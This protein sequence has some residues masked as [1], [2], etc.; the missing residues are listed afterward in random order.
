MAVDQPLSR[1]LLALAAASIVPL[2][3]MAGI[4]L[5][6]LLTRQR[7]ES[8]RAG[9]ELARSVAN[10]VGAELREA[11]SVLETLATTP[12]LD[13]LDAPIF[14]E[15]A[16]R[17]LAARPHWIAIVLTDAAGSPLA[18]TRTPEGR[19]ALPVIDPDSLDRASST[20]DAV[21]G[22]LTQEADTW[23]FPV[24]VPVRREGRTVYVIS[25]LISP[26][27]VREVLT[28]QDVPADWVISIVDSNGRRVARSRAHEET[29]G[30]RLSETAQQVVAGGNAEGVGVSYALEG[31]RILTPYSRL[32]WSSWTAVLGIP[33]TVVDAGVFRAVALYGVGVVLSLAIAAL[34]SVWVARTIVRPVR[35]LGLAASAMAHG[36]RP[37]TP[38]SSI[39]EVAAA[40]LALRRA[41]DDLR[42]GESER[43]ALLQAERSAREA[44]ESSDRAKDQF[45]AM[46]SH[47]LRT[48][49]NAV[50]GWA[51]MLKSGQLRDDPALTERAIG[52]IVRNADA[53]VQLIDDLLDLSRI[54]VGKLELRLC[55]TDLTLVL[56]DVME[57]VQPAAN[58]GNVRLH[59]AF[60]PDAGSITGDPA[61]LR[62]VVW[63]L[64]MNSVKFTP[65]GGSVEVAL[66]RPD[67]HLEVVV[68]DTGRGIPAEVLP[69][70]FDRFHQADGSSTRTHGGLGLGLSLVKTLVELHGGTVLAESEG[71]G[72]GATFTVRFPIETREAAD[73]GDVRS[74]EPRAGTKDGSR[75]NLDGLRV[76]IVD[77]DA[78]SLVLAREVLRRSGADV[79]ACSTAGAALDVFRSWRPDVVVSDIE[80]PG[81]DGY[82]LIRRIRA[83]PVED[84]GRTPAIALTAYG[85]AHNRRRALDAGF[86]IHVAKPVE[87]GELTTI[88][89]ELARTTEPTAT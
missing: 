77:D 51:W 73:A 79:R 22:P 67:G 32:A 12:S 80:M 10:A 2:A 44:A 9:I 57:A 52:A 7:S 48:P 5:Y 39:R 56:Q 27:V 35:A 81:E 64:V 1:R 14:I 33:T 55:E 43:E 69:L 8:E 70:V 21:V 89:A 82:Q 40:G 6:A 11:E 50:S 30:G 24:R 31:E 63:N 42:R 49:L 59:C 38:D 34:A 53:Q 47:E 74:R 45:L 62:Q 20:G 26:D 16:G 76:L 87:P 84:G 60:A 25:A 3:L 78:E 19:S 71:E 83:L 37:P 88:I 29:L 85:G 54:T 46:L 58:A 15:R 72:R 65:S 18:D 86:H 36:E 4:G 41:F 28:R 13:R 66:H 17:V 23:L 61:R 68:R 75:G